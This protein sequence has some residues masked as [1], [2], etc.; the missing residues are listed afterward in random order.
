MSALFDRFLKDPSQVSCGCDD[1]PSCCGSSA[2]KKESGEGWDAKTAK[3]LTP[4]DYRWI[5]GTKET[6]A[7][8]IPLVSTGFGTPERLGSWR[9]RWGIGRMKYIIPPGLYGVGDPDAWSSVF[10]TGNYKMTFDL[11]RRALA[12]RSAWILVL[13]TRG[14]NV[15]CAAGK[16]TFGTDELVNRIALTR[17]AAVVS[18]RTLIL[19][20]LGAPGVASH[21]VTKRTKFRVLFGPV[22]VADLPAFIDAGMKAAPEMR[23]VRFAFRDRIILAP[24]EIAAVVVN[25]AFWVIIGLWIAGLLGLKIFAFN[26]PAVIGALLIGAVA[27]PALLPWIPVRRF[28]LKGWMLGMVGTIAFLAVRGVPAT[29]AGWVSAASYLLCLPAFSAF[30]GMGFTGSSPITSLSGVVKEMKTAVPLIVLSL[31]L[32]VAALVTSAVI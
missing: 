24:E 4:S 5:I 6:P 18:H 16:G 12:G 27:V 28:S 15:W 13:D 29:A 21:E 31:F 17:L 23:R 14:I 20:E 9:S 11:V 3:P 22:R 30:I 32:G 10:V 25:P 19:P 26:L 7:G 8:P 1:G 2:P